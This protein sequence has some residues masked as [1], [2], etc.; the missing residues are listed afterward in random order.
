M[1]WVDFLL[2]CLYYN[3]QPEH[4]QKTWNEL[5]AIFN[6]LLQSHHIVQD[7]VSFLPIFHYRYWGKASQF[8]SSAFQFI[9]RLSWLECPVVHLKISRRSSLD[10][11]NCT[12]LCVFIYWILWVFRTCLGLQS[13]WNVTFE[14]LY[15]WCNKCFWH[16]GFR[17]CSHH[18]S[19]HLAL[20]HNGMRGQSP[21]VFINRT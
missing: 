8:S 18:D 20:T 5:L 2:L 7:K 19:E 12:V 4:T 6:I 17:M 14:E 21:A 9:L 13:L 16:I 11:L 15:S 3:K 10:I 1:N